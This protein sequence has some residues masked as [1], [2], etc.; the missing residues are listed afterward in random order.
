LIVVRYDFEQGDPDQRYEFYLYSSHNNYQSPLQKVTG[1]VG[2]GIRPG[3]GKIMYWDA[4]QELGNF[5]GNL[6]LKIKGDTYVPIVEF[7]NFASGQTPRKGKTMDIE[8]STECED[9]N[10]IQIE[11]LCGDDIVATCTAPNDGSYTWSIPKKIKKGKAYRVKISEIDNQLR[12]ESS[13]EFQIKSKTPTWIKV[14]PAAAVVGTAA[15][16]LGTN[17]SQQVIAEPPGLPTR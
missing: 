2:P 13:Q 11:I 1:D 12:C 5:K 17:G 6:N 7:Q 8:W 14:V 16:L 3:S 10:E 9:I 15:I 4:K